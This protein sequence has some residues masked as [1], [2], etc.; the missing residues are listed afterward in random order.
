VGGGLMIV[1]KSGRRWQ[2]M[3]MH[4][5]TMEQGK[6][7]DI[8]KQLGDRKLMGVPDIILRLVVIVATNTKL[9]QATINIFAHFALNSTATGYIATKTAPE[10]IAAALGINRA[11][12][13]RAYAAL[14]EAGHIGWNRTNGFERFQGISWRVWIIVPGAPE[15]A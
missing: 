2:G 7:E 14:E 1:G 4:G 9:S 15:D 10:E 5:L 6:I 12:V 11:T 3:R 8:A 13:F